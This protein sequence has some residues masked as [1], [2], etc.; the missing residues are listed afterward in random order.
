MNRA[1]YTLFF[2]LA[3]G[4]Q[5]TQAQLADISYQVRVGNVTSWENY[6]SC[7]F[8]EGPC[9]EAGDEEYTAYA[10]FKDN[11]NA[12]LVSTGCLTCNA[13]GDCSY[14]WGT[15]IG[16]RT[17]NAYSVIGNIDAWESDTDWRCTF[18]SGDDCRRV[19]DVGTYLIREA[20]FPGN[21]WVSGPTWGTCSESHALRLEYYWNYANAGSIITP[22]YNTQNVAASSGQIR[23]WQVAMTAGEVYFFSTCGLTTE[24]TYLRLYGTDGRTIVAQNDDICGLQ[25]EI[26]YL[27]PTTGT[28]YIELSRFSRNPLNLNMSLNY[29][30]RK[31]GSNNLYPINVGTLTCSTNYSNTQNNATSNCFGNTIGQSSDDI[32]YQFTMSTPGWVDVGSCSSGFDTYLHIANASGTIIYSNDD[33]GPLC[34]GTRASLREFLPTGTYFAISEGF[35][36]SSGSVTT[37]IKLTTPFGG[38]ISGPSTVCNAATSQVY[39]VSGVT[40]AVNYSWSVPAGAF[41]LSGAGT[42]SITMSFGSASS[43]TISVTPTNY[44]AFPGCT[45]TPLTFN[46]TVLA[47]VLSGNVNPSA[48][49]ICYGADASNI[50]FSTLPSGGSGSFGFQWY[51]RD[52]SNACPT[53]SSTGGW[54]AITGATSNNYTPTA[55]TTTRTYAVRVD[56]IGT[57]D[58]GIAQ[59]ATDCR[60]VTVL[61]ALNRGTVSNTSET[62]CFGGDPSNI[63][64]STAPS[65]GAGT[66]NFQWYYQD[67]TP[68]C[69]SSGSGTAGWTAISGATTNSYDPP[70]GLGTT[71]TYALQVDP[72]GSPDCGGFDWSNSCRVV[73]VVD[74]P[75]A[76]TATKSPNVAGV[77]EGTT[78]TITG[79]T[80]MGG[81]TGTCNLEYR[82]NTGSGFG[83]WSG[84]IPSFAAIEGTNVIEVRKSCSGNGC[85]PATNSFFWTVAA[86]PT[87]AD[88]GTDQDNCNSGSFTLAANSPIVGIGSWSVIAGSAAVS[89]PTSPSSPVTGVPL[90]TSAT[91]R[92]TIASGACTSSTDDVV[93][94]NE[95]PPSS[96]VI[97]S[98]NYTCSGSKFELVGGNPAIGDGSW[99]I[100]AGTATLTPE[101]ALPRLADLEAIDFNSTVTARYTV[102][103]G[104][105]SACPDN[106]Q[107]VDLDFLTELATAADPSVTCTPIPT[108]GVQYWASSGGE[109]LYL[110]LDPNNNNIGAT[111]VELPG[112]D[113]FSSPESYFGGLGDV[114]EGAFGG[115]SANPARMPSGK[116][117]CPEELFLEDIFEIN[118]ANQPINTDPILT[119]YIP[120]T[121]WDSFVA[122]GNVWLDAVEGRRVAYEDC[123][124]G[125]PASSPSIEPPST[126]NITVTGYHDDGRSLHAVSTVDYLAAGDYYAITFATDRFS[127]FVIHGSGSG[128]PLPVQLVSFT[129]QHEDGV[130]LLEW[131]TATE[132]NVSH[133]ELERSSDGINFSKIA[134]VEAA[135]Q[136]TTVQSYSFVDRNIAPG[137]YYYRLKMLD[138]DASFEYSKVIYLSATQGVS[139]DQYINIVPNP[140][141]DKFEVQFY[142]AQSGMYTVQITDM[143]GKPVTEITRNGDKGMVVVPIDLSDKASGSYLVRVTRQDGMRLVRQVIKSTD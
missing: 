97:T 65:G 56:P 85:D 7:G 84:T 13:N 28:Y 135:G 90:G 1:Y 17:N 139:I 29:Y 100:I 59:W 127:S 129:G 73:T 89:T 43:G 38:S 33:N 32:W 15:Y 87:V 64:L 71:R 82:F 12:S 39:T 107:E 96:A 103:N 20:Q 30:K 11:V 72:T 93:L 80:D 54:T 140:F 21:S 48:E 60:V 75:E 101:L 23:S 113:A 121:K 70:S 42:S 138:L 95:T 92:W 46:V 2:A 45:G 124:I 105:S 109:K 34:G 3:L 104:P 68:G 78:L 37:T 61:P 136:T 36:T 116:P 122:D 24:D 47:P 77:C 108:G 49:T 86:N 6:F 126:A 16:G 130:N 14:G 131:V 76:P 18:S 125:F 4:G 99:S 143:A 74:D 41:I 22:C 141:T 94:T 112:A 67:G 50:S 19:G 26:G 83:S 25:S 137:G 10:R 79:V 118:V 117:S 128:D 52:G 110:A 63:N 114:P 44:N 134:S 88:A 81:G 53:G 66:F 69:P 58:C 35:S 119:V 120:K 111:S 123:Y 40:G 8:W 133:F 9:W 91:L 102:T 31:P 62:I 27:A 142:H 98:T 57:P 51:Y 106:T 132:F 115:G 5:I 55:V